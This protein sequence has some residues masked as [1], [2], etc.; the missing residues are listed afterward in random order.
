MES[1]EMNNILKQQID[2]YEARA[3]EYDDWYYRRGRYDWGIEKNLDW[4]N[5]ADE[6]RRH[7]HEFRGFDDTLELASGTGVWTAELLKTSKRVTCLDASP[8]MI[9]LNRSKNGCKK[10]D[11]QR[12]DLFQ[13]E[14]DHTFDL[15]FTS[16]WLSHIPRDQLHRF[17]KNIAGAMKPDGLFYFIDSQLARTSRAQNHEAPE[18]DTGFSHRKL[19]DGREFEIVKIFH[20]REDLTRQLSEAGLK[21]DVKTTDNYFLY[22]TAARC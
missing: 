18:V 7:F 9:E 20:G 10:I 16:F 4:A 17:L 14:P 19:N 1:S 12:V 8:K 6:I 5:E 13:W 2:Y 15:V 3:P 11:F 22:G 21:A